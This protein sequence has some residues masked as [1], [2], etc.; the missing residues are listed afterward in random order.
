MAV[1]YRV[2][3]ANFQGTRTR[4]QLDFL[5]A[6]YTGNV[7]PLVGTDDPVSIEWVRDDN[8]YVP[9]LGSEMNID[10]DVQEEGQYVDFNGFPE[11]TFE[12]RLRYELSPGVWKTYWGGWINPIGTVLTPSTEPIGY[13]QVDHHLENLQVIDLL[14]L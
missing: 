10:L 5:R 14:D 13:Y 8:P 12:V 2:E 7:I 9:I 3:F 1:N 6:G 4:W 11:F